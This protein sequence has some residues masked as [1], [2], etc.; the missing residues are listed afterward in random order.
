MRR[1]T[2]PIGPAGPLVDVEI[3]VT[4]L[5]RA[6]LIRNGLSPPPSV[7][8]AMLV[9]T[10]ASHT[11]IAAHQLASLNLSPID[12]LPYH[13]ASTEG[14]A[15]Q[16]DVYPVSLTLGS[17]ADQNLCRWDPFEIMATTFIDRQHHGLLGRDVLS[18][19]QLE[20]NGRT[21]LL[22]MSYP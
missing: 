3:G 5:L 21:G 16:C 10:G 13:T 17:L 6:T 11:F 4:T 15:A 18:K 7:R 20:W 8:V 14:V 1:L 9:D 2:I 12:S 22:V 19:V